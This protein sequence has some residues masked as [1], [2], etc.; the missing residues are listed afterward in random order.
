MLASRLL[1]S[2]IV[3]QD[4]AAC[5]KSIGWPERIFRPQGQYKTLANLPVG[6]RRAR[7]YPFEKIKD[8]S[9]T[10]KDACNSNCFEF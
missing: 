7:L 3:F 5:R 8:P 2:G 6:T 1:A 10:D 9:C 4:I